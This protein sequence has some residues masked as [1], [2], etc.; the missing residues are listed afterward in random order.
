MDTQYK[1]DW[2]KLKKLYEQ[3][4]KIE[5]HMLEFRKLLSLGVKLHR[6][7]CTWEKIGRD[8]L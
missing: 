4:V 1:E 8:D 6:V 2:I 3:K 7:Y 5:E